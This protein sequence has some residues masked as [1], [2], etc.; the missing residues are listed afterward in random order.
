MKLGH[1]E[2]SEDPATQSSV[3]PHEVSTP[4]LQNTPKSHWIAE[5]P[6]AL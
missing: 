5:D 4:P 3:A 1:V 6:E 2:V